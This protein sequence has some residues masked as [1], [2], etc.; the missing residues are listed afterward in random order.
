[1]KNKNKQP[2]FTIVELMVVIVVIGVLAGIAY[3][4]FSGSKRRAEVAS[5]HDGTSKM[6]QGFQSALVAEERAT[7]WHEAHWANAG[8]PNVSSENPPIKKLIENTDIDSFI[9]SVPNTTNFPGSAWRYDADNTTAY[10]GCPSVP[11]DENGVNLIIPGHMDITYIQELDKQMD[12]GNLDCGKGR[13]IDKKYF[14]LLSSS[15]SDVVN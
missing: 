1:M 12:D 9:S 11:K 13:L 8:Y 4:S 5:A 15:L 14:W 6:I 10:V 2:G 3:N 7:W